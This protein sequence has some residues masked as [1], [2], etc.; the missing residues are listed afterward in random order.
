MIFPSLS[1]VVPFEDDYF[2][3]VRYLFVH[4]DI[5]VLFLM[6]IKM[7]NESNMNKNCIVMLGNFH[8]LKTNI[9]NPR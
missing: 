9:Y 5:I 3:I 2:P 8:V 4:A 7:M 1:A 6:E